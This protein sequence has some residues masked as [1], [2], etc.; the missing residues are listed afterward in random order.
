MCVLRDHRSRRPHR[1]PARVSPN[2]KGGGGLLSGMA[3]KLL[4]VGIALILLYVAVKF[5]TGSD[6]GEEAVDRID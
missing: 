5:L 6:E 2:T 3:R 4:K 1:P